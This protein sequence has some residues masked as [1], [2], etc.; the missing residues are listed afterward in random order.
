MWIGFDHGSGAFGTDIFAPELRETDK[1][2]LFGGKRIGP[3]REVA[4]QIAHQRINASLAPLSAVFSP[5]VSRPFGLAL[6]R[7][8]G[9]VLVRDAGGALVEFALSLSDHPVLQIAGRIEAGS[10]VVESRQLVANTTPIA[11]VNIV[12]RV[13]KN[14]AK[15]PAKAR[16]CFSGE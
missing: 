14:G 8:E 7:T 3:R 2:T 12:D 10:R 11:I 5:G 9:T 6:D 16:C 15:M 1:E 4:H 13:V